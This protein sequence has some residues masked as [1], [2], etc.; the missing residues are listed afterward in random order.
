MSEGYKIGRLRGDFVIVFRDSAGKRHRY[1]LGTADASEAKRLAPTIY[2][3]LTRPRSTSVTDLWRAFVQDRAG[4][5]VIATMS[6]PWKALKDRFGAMATSAITIEDCRAHA[7]DRRRSDIKDS[8][9]YT[10]LGRLRMVLKWAERHNLIDKAPYIERPPTPKPREGYLTRAQARQLID[11]ATVPHVRLFIVLAL[12]TGA[13]KQALLD[14]TWDRCNFERELIDLRDPRIT[15]P[16][17]GRAIVPMNRTIKAALLNAKPGAL[18]DYVIEWAG[19]KVTSVKKGLSSAAKRAGIVDH[20]HPHL[21]R[22]SAAVHM[23][24]AGIPMEEI[25]QYLGH[26]DINVTRRIYARFSPDYLRQAASALEYDDLGS[27]NQ[28][29]QL[30]RDLSPSN[31]GAGDGIRTHDPNLGKVVLYP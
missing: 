8:T 23:A 2:A 25:A 16:H 19:D 22:H 11:A 26:R 14:L 4:R 18:S 13:R 29:N 21:L 1:S 10:E 6:A 3:E 20:V 17:K 9:I 12:G 15:V 28:G 5:A 24:E 31:L 27:L 30:K 7:A